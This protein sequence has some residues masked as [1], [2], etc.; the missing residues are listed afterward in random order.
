M[1]SSEG[2]RDIAVRFPVSMLDRACTA[3][4][5]NL[6]AIAEGMG[7]TCCVSGENMDTFLPFST[8]ARKQSDSPSV[9][10]DRIS[11]STVSVISNSSS[12]HASLPDTAFFSSWSIPSRTAQL[13]QDTPSS[14]SVRKKSS[15]HEYTEA[16]LLRT[17]GTSLGFWRTCRPPPRGTP[18]KLPMAVW[19]AD[20]SLRREGGMG[21]GSVVKSWCRTGFKRRPNAP[22]PTC[23]IPPAHA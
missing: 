1:Q 10:R 14:C 21:R 13:E 23:S 5:N 17:V 12:S 20:A 22:L 11:R 2:S 18:A 16:L 8:S 7:S 19:G 9:R 6:S 3:L 4:W 15:R